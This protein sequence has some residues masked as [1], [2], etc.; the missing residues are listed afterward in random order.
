LPAGGLGRGVNEQFVIALSTFPDAETARKIARELVENAIVACANVVPS[1][2]S[3]YFWKDKVE[4][5][6]EILAI[7]KM[8]AARYAEFESRLRELHP[9][10]VP[11]IVRLNIAEGSPDYLRWI[12]ESCARTSSRA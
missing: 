11:E 3:I 6:A 5:S 7:F 4:T 2:E 9:Y 12:A 10:D 1:V 8:T